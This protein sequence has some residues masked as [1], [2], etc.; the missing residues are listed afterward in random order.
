MSNQ[1]AIRQAGNLA[2]LAAAHLVVCAEAE[3]S[4][5]LLQRPSSPLGMKH[6]YGF[7]FHIYFVR[8]KQKCDISETETNEMNTIIKKRYNLVG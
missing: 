6:L 2:S 3:Q 8:R 7:Y 1:A 4:L 5:A